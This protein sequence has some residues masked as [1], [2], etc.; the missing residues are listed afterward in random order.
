MIGHRGAADAVQGPPERVLH[1]A[2]PHL[3][4]DDDRSAAE[5]E[6]S[7]GSRYRNL[8]DA[9]GCTHRSTGRGESAQPGN[10]CGA[11][12]LQRV[13]L[14]F[15]SQ[16]L[17]VVANGLNAMGHLAGIAEDPGPAAHPEPHP[18][19]GEDMAVPLPYAAVRELLPET[20]ALLSGHPV[21]EA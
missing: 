15:E 7:G 8:R 16:C 9:G 2:Q 19:A 17:F 12:R 6:A 13:R 11:D 3:D 10:G 5:Q 18:D 14:R 1:S 20:E 4:T 21:A